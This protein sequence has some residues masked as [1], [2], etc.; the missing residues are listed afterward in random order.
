MS[1]PK[2]RL[3]RNY[4]IM[5]N[6][7]HGQESAYDPPISPEKLAQ[8]QF[9]FVEG[10]PVDAYVCDIGPSCGY[11]VSYPTKVKNLE[12]LVDRFNDPDVLIGSTQMWRHGENLRRLWEAG[13]DP[14][15]LKLNEAKRL[16][17][18]FWFRLNMND[19]HHVDGEGKNWRLM[20]SKFFAEHPEYWIGDDGVDTAWPKATQQGIKYFQNFA[21]EEVRCLRLDI[22]AEACQRYDVDGFHYDFMRCPGYFKYKEVE[23]NLV[24]MT[25]FIRD[26]RTI[27][28]EIGT[29]KN[30]QIGLCVRVPNT[31][32]GARK[33][34]LDVKT[35]IEEDLVDIVVPSTFFSADTQEDVS[36]WVELARNSPVRIN[37]AIEEAYNA[38]YTGGVVRC[39][40]SPPVMLPLT[41]EMANAIAARH[42][43]KGVDGL[44][45]FNWYGTVNSYNY[46]NRPALD[47]IGNPLRLKYK[48]KRYTVMRTDESF[49]N[50]LPHP[51]QL[52]VTLDATAKTIKLDIAD[53]LSE[54][55][56]RVKKVCLQVYLVNMTVEDEIELKFN[57]QVLECLNLLR[58]GEY[59]ALSRHWYD[60]DVPSRLV[61]FGDNDISVYVIKRNKR[62]EKELS[63]E[64]T[65]LELKIEYNYPNGCWEGL[66]C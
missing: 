50:C 24:V 6:Q 25:Q 17:V 3:S 10:T 2:G 22:T 11:A 5:W 52:P 27:L 51:R 14:L 45:L 26:T 43:S 40:Y 38:G 1:K 55:V 33:L 16:G 13:V 57:G 8:G 23:D 47:D 59:D 64:I 66:R 48:N 58:P 28:D 62:L 21:F 18:D 60:Y 41:H 46:D 53:D 56:D 39:F 42:W 44:Y 4:R 20:G 9:G 12:F 54:S 7:D 61:Q 49:P 34:G 31:V 29:K 19:W 36:E 15:K 65:D 35:W 32:A 30:K 37:P 63:I